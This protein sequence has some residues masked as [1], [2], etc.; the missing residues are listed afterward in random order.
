MSQ[1]LR[2]EFKMVASNRRPAPKPEAAPA[3]R[4]EKRRVD[5]AARKARNLALAYYIDGLVRS[6]KVADYAAMAITCGVS[7]TI[8]TRVLSC[9]ATPIVKQD[10]I[11]RVGSVGLEK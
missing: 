10:R 2:V 9:C 4:T 6:G 1:E 5:R 8:V 7:R 3:T 11:L